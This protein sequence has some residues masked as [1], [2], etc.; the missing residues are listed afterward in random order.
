MRIYDIV[1]DII[2]DKIGDLS[3]MPSFDKVFS[4]YM[5][6]RYL[7][8]RPEYLEYAEWVNKYGAILSNDAV[9]KYLVRHVPRSDSGYVDYIKRK[10]KDVVAVDSE[11]AGEVVPAS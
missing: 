3:L 8:M 5:V 1:R 7:S 10:K 9:Y 11:S 6:A 4:S 2:S